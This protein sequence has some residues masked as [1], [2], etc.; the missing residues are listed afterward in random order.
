MEEI[1]LAIE[2]HIAEHC[3]F[4]KSI[5][6]NEGQLDY[7]GNEIPLKYPACLIEFTD[8]SF[9]DLS[10]GLQSGS[11]NITFQVATQKLT[12]SSAKAPDHQKRKALEILQHC[13]NL[14]EK[15]HNWRP[16]P[17]ASK[18]LRRRIVKQRRDD[19]ILV[20]TIIYSMQISGT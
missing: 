5:D 16:L 8:G 4:F 17:T 2:K 3:V 7:Y 12:N 9:N 13:Q 20:Y 18:L 19:G 1:L 10:Q 14:H 15:I 11:V 6:I